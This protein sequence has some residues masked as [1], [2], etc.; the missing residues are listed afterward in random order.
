MQF[1]DGLFGTAQGVLRAMGG[2]VGCVVYNF[3]GFWGGGVLVGWL[4][5]FKVRRVLVVAQR[6]H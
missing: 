4:L 6:R 1:S 2:Q 5:T 3:V